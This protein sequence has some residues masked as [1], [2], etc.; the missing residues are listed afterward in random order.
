[1]IIAVNTGLCIVNEDIFTR[2]ENIA[3][4]SLVNPLTRLHASLTFEIT[5]KNATYSDVLN[6]Y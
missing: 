5:N 3:K 1:M 6:H 4:K 2:K